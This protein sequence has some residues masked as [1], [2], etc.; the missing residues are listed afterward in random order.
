MSQKFV[1]LFFNKKTPA[2]LH[3]LLALLF[4]VTAIMACGNTKTTVPAGMQSAEPATKDALIN[5]TVEGLMSGTA[6]LVGVYADQNFLADSAKVSP[7][8]SFTFQRDSAYLSGLYFVIVPGDKNFQV[9]IDANQHF[10]MKTKQ[11]DFVKYMEV[12]GS[13]DNTLLYESLKF[14]AEVDKK[15]ENIQKRLNQLAKNSPEYAQAKAEQD[16]L[17]TERAEHVEKFRKNH[18]TAF[19]TKFKIAGQNPPIEEPKKPDGTLDTIMQSYLYRSKFWNDV[20]FSDVRLLRTPVI[21]NK[22]K[23]YITEIT[24][25]IPDSIIKSATF[26]TDK[27]LANKEMFKFVANWIALQYQATKTKVMGGEAVYAYMIDKYFT[28]ELAYWSD[29]TEI[30]GLRKQAAEIGVSVLGKTGQD[31]RAKDPTGQYRSL[32]DLKTP[33]LLVYIYNPD[34]EHCQKETPLIKQVY[35]KWKPK[36]FFDVFAIATETDDAKWKNYIA[37]EKL[38]FTNVFDP[39]YESKYYLKYHIDIT[40]E[41]YLLNKDRKIIAMNIDAAQLDQLLTEEFSKK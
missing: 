21:H 31:V 24:P 39:T 1:Q 27:S 37:K 30:K 2:M 34:C 14:Q 5:I 38:T 7:E 29:S 15:F 13:I 9:I 23:R 36:G 10:S 22:L 8:G 12:T 41:L 18:P 28:R 25:Q 16:K 33:Y 32:Y 11:G 6:K 4:F 19:F 3:K 20:D 40:P 26:V 17:L 35:E